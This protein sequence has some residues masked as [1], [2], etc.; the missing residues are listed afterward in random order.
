[1]ANWGDSRGARLGVEKD[2]LI[3]LLLFDNFVF[4]SCD[5]WRETCWQHIG[6]FHVQFHRI[7]VVMCCSN[8]GAL[9]F[10]FIKSLSG[11]KLRTKILNGIGKFD[12]WCVNAVDLKTWGLRTWGFKEGNIMERISLTWNVSAWNVSRYWTGKSLFTFAER[13]KMLD[14]LR[15]PKGHE[16]MSAILCLV[17]ALP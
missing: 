14:T 8:V 13:L 16:V 1:M 6:P 7:A 4:P 3:V 11:V 15:W 2:T 17:K 10:F 5:V 12:N 9:T